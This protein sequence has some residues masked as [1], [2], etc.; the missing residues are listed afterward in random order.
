VELELELEVELELELAHHVA[1]TLSLKIV[2]K[3]TG[4]RSKAKISKDPY[5][6]TVLQ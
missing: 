6:A 1:C 3:D 2:P 5:L 4:H